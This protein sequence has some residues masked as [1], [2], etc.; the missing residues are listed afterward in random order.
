M[1][2]ERVCPWWLGYLLASPLR[3]LYQN[4]DTLLAPYVKEGMT[5]LDVGPGM[6]FFTLPAAKLVGKSG[7]AIAVDLQEKMI[8]SLKRRAARAGLADRVE[9]RVCSNTSLGIDDLAGKVDV[10]LAFAVIHEMP[11]AQSAIRDIV[12]TLKSGGVFCIAEPKGHC[13]LEGFHN[14]VALA[15]SNGMSEFESPAVR[16]SYTSI[17]RKA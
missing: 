8:G 5:V 14:T 15:V 1:S 12:R 10:A 9:T 13:S 7:R 4:P 6:G 17:L 2:E 3:R 16:G 11:D